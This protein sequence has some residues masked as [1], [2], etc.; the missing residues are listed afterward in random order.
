MEQEECGIC[1]ADA[2]VKEFVACHACKGRCCRTCFERFLLGSSTLT[3][4]CMFVTCAVEIPWEQIVAQTSSVFLNGAYKERRCA[5]LMKAESTKMEDTQATTRAYLAA[6]TVLAQQ[7]YVKL[8][9]AV[10]EN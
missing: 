1:C 5:L 3:P 10:L 7:H 9:P 2:E 4:K 8:E 6:Q